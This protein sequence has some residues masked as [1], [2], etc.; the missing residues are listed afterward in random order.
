MKWLSLFA[1]A[2]VFTCVSEVALAQPALEVVGSTTI[3]WGE[4]TPA[5][6]PLSAQIEVRNTGNSTL[7][8]LSVKPACGCT[9]APLEKDK[10]EGGES[11]V[12]NVKINVATFN[13]PVTK[14]I[15]ITSNDPNQAQ[16]T[17][18]LKAKVVRD[19]TLSPRFVSFRKL[20]VG[21]EAGEIVRIQNTSKKA[22]TVTGISASEGFEISPFQ[23][24][25][26]KPGEQLEFTVSTTPA[27]SGFVRGTVDIVTDHPSDEFATMTMKVYGNARE[28]RKSSIF[29][30]ANQ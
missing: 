30:D 1:C 6:S 7:E 17:I 29:L 24:R 8:I 20:E 19:V 18:F 2:I 15:T 10:L 5:E 28:P 3:D 16:T 25:T 27:E 9:T 22:V 4:V 26:L 13:G 11:T 21:K 12:I 14:T 23:K